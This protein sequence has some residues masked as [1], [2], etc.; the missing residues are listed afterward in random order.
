MEKF[1]I[2]PAPRW[3]VHVFYGGAHLFRRGIFHKL[4]RWALAMPQA[5]AAPARVREKLQNE[6]IEDFRIDFEDGF[7]FRAEMEE[8]EAASKAGQEFAACALHGELPLRI[9]LR[10]KCDL[11]R[12]WRT[13]ESFLTAGLGEGFPATFV[14]TQPK[15]QGPEEAR[16]WRELLE[17]AEAHFGLPALTLRHE[18]L[19]EDPRATRTLPEIAAACE[20]R[21]EAAH[22]GAY[23]YLSSLGVPFPAQGLSHPY[24]IQ[25]RHR[26]LEVF[27]PLKVPVSDGAYNE[28][29][30]G[31]EAAGIDRALLG[32][33][34]QVRR[35]LAE[36]IFCGWDLHPGQLLSRY[37]ALFGYFER[38]VDEA[39]QRYRAFLDAETKARVS[40]TTFDDA[41]TVQGL[42]V[43][44]ARGICS[45]ALPLD[46]LNSDA[47]T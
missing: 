26:M 8:D 16:R 24:A 2:E 15:L 18:I 22:F 32:H 47:A 39:L 4:G 33:E 41:A 10:L 20:N 11:P 34:E 12:A 40:G 9:G 7:G 44:L 21:L 42:R 3:P 31:A 43:F 25:A 28:L 38:H 30:T 27:S 35:A 1:T 17:R 37:R 5:A 14:I 29:P 45:G 19:I 36:G 6:P 23:D 46:L 13:L